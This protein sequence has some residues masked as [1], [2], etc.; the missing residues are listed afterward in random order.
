MSNAFKRYCRVTL[1]TRPMATVI[2]GGCVPNATGDISRGLHINF[3]VHKQIQI[4]F[5]SKE[6]TIYNLAPA[7]RARI[8]GQLGIRIDAGFLGNWGCIFT[9]HSRVIDHY[10]EGTEWVTHIQ[11]GDGHDAAKYQH[12]QSYPSGVSLEQITT[13]LAAKLGLGSGNLRE[14]IRTL[15]KETLQQ[16]STGHAASGNALRQL[17]TL[18]RSA[19]LH[20]SVQDGAIQVMKGLN[21]VRGG[22]SS[23]RGGAPLISVETGLIGSPQHVAWKP[24][25]PTYTKFKSILNSNL[26]IGHSVVLKSQEVSGVF[27]VMKLTHEGD[28]DGQDW[29][30]SVECAPPGTRV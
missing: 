10:R 26:K 6:L 24:N 17:D 30:T 12:Y 25:W 13:D 14:A 9:G 20:W 15:G 7:T 2:E 19:G 22:A 3:H 1:T 18:I 8:K 5:N 28:T 23:S 27:T 21:P 29:Y 11:S 16:L 4:E